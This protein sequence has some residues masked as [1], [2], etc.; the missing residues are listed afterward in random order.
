MTLPTRLALR[1]RASVSV[2]GNSGTTSLLPPADVTPQQAALETHLV[3]TITT[4]FP[5]LGKRGRDTRHGKHPTA[6]GAQRAVRRP[7]STGMEHDGVIGHVRKVDLVT[8]AWRIGISRGRDDR[9]DRRFR[10]EFQFSAL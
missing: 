4:P 1:S 7:R 5:R 6:G 10:G 8:A 3:G 9:R 2:S